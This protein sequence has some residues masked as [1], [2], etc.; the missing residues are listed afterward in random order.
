[1]V[2]VVATIAYAIVTFCLSTVAAAAAV[3]LAP[4]LLFLP[5][6]L[7]GLLIVLAGVLLGGLGFV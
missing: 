7:F 2:S 1:L 6:I 3:L 4:W 5:V